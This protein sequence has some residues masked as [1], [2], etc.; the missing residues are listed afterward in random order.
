MIKNAKNNIINDL[1]DRD[2]KFNLFLVDKDKKKLIHDYFIDI[3]KN[4]YCMYI[5]PDEERY[6][7][8]MVKYSLYSLHSH[9]CR[10][11]DLRYILNYAIDSIVDSLAKKT[12]VDLHVIIDNY[13]L[14]DDDQRNTINTFLERIDKFIKKVSVIYQCDKADFKYLKHKIKLIT[15][16]KTKSVHEGNSLKFIVKDVLK[17]DDIIDDEV[18]N[19]CLYD[20]KYTVYYLDAMEEHF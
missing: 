7:K 16:Y 13:E 11:E 2:F 9:I 12:T 8:L 20:I 19:S 3:L 6:N 1:I 10:V 5:V 14:L 15:L 4:G 17:F 18:L